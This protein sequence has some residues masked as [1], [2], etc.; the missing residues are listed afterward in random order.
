MIIEALRIMTLK[1]EKASTETTSEIFVQ[2]STIRTTKILCRILNFPCLW[3]K[4]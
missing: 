2:K 1:L 4:T 3:C